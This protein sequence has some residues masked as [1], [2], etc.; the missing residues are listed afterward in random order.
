MTTRY[1]SLASSD[2]ATGFPT[3]DFSSLGHGNE[4][5]LSQYLLLQALAYDDS[6]GDST[7][8]VLTSVLERQLEYLR[9]GKQFP[10]KSTRLAW[11]ARGAQPYTPTATA[12]STPVMGANQRE[13]IAASTAGSTAMPQ[14]NYMQYESEGFHTAQ[15]VPALSLPAFTPGGTATV[16]SRPSSSGG[17]RAG[18]TLPAGLARQQG[19][20]ISHL[21]ASMNMGLSQQIDTSTDLL[22][23][24]MLRNAKAAS[25][26]STLAAPDSPFLLTPVSRRRPA[27]SAGES[28]RSLRKRAK[29]RDRLLQATTHSLASSQYSPLPGHQPQG[30]ASSFRSKGPSGNSTYAGPPKQAHAQQ[31]VASLVEEVR[32]SVILKRISTGS[33]MDAS[34]GPGVLS[35]A[36]SCAILDHV[37]EQYDPTE[38]IAQLLQ[39]V[40]L[41][42]YRAIYADFSGM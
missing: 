37:L 38:E 34:G 29:S 40:R 23:A 42:L 17:P 5:S 24:E 36:L 31:R 2:G 9:T 1:S 41:G 25:T 26:I 7:A 19:A 15:S 28:S 4:D 22:A 30:A 8:S 13:G 18:R 27:T 39:V 32:N 6:H 10:S 3:V 33:M 21:A 11:K 14:L 12:A 16:R 35:T 20:S